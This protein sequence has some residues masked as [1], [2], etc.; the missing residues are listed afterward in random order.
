MAANWSKPTLD[1][2]YT[3][4][5][6]ELIERADDHAKMFNSTN[7]TNLPPGVVKWNGSENK[8]DIKIPAGWE[9]LSTEY[10]INVEK[11]GGLTSSEYTNTASSQN[12]TGAKVFTNN[13]EIQG[14]TTL[15]G[16]VVLG[17]SANNAVT[18]NAKVENTTFSGDVTLEGVNTD[19][20]VGGN[21]ALGGTLSVSGNSVLGG[22]LS[23]SSNFSVNGHT[24]LGN[25]SSD[26]ITLTGTVGATTFNG[27][28]TLSGTSTDLTVGGA[29]TVAG[30]TTLN[31]NVTLGNAAADTILINGDIHG[32]SNT[33]DIKDALNLSSTLTVASTADFNSSITT[34]AITMDNDYHFIAGSNGNHNGDF[35]WYS[36]TAGEYF[37]INGGTGNTTI[38]GVNSQFTMHGQATVAG[39]S[40]TPLYMYNDGRLYLSN[41]AEATSLS[42]SSVSLTVK[43]GATVAKNLYVGGTIY[44]SSARELK[45]N[46]EPLVGSL[47]KIRLLEGVSYNKISNGQKEIGLIAD[48]VLKVIP[49]VVSSKDGKAE[50]LHYSRLTAVLI[51]AVKELTNKVES[52]EA[53]I[54]RS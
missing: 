21:S 11:L 26:T 46:I 42:D 20:S 18:F 9:D 8:F 25:A 36:E 38:H 31:G 30:A 16:D 54:Q 13:T 4:F 12:I 28:V 23:V 45:E 19:L 50:A 7:T 53:Q 3:V 24:T 6:D 40:T 22:T 35:I 51:E 32:A 41:T 5:R 44:E 33:V 47:G 10:K 27:D 15:K 34:R 29:I 52:L 48:E 14:T 43:G 2:L 39:A 49:E 1:S 17:D 37:E